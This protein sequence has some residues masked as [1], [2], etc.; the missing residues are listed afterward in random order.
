MTPRL[1]CGKP[2][3]I[4]WSTVGGC[5]GYFETCFSAINFG[6]ESRILPMHK[7]CHTVTM[8]ILDLSIRS[9]SCIVVK[10][11]SEAGVIDRRFLPA[12]STSHVS[13]L[14][15][16]SISNF[17]IVC[18]LNVW[19]KET[20]ELRRVVFIA[21]GEIVIVILLLLSWIKCNAGLILKFSKGTCRIFCRILHHRSLCTGSKRSFSI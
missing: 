6:K 15:C 21:D 9:R 18:P 8:C 16:S 1:K 17:T 2:R 13:Y 19:G 5:W 12:C 10:L 14:S 4:W 3:H 11:L 7:Y 20:I